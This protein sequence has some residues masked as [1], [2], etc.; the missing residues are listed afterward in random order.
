MEDCVGIVREEDELKQGV[1]RLE[2]LKPRVAQVK[3]PGA[4]QY[5]P[6]W[7]EAIA[8]KSL[9]VSSEA[10]ARAALLRKESRGAHT[11]VDY[12]GE[13]DEWLKYNIVI[14]KG[15]ADGEMQ[16]EKI[17]RPAPTPYLAEIANAK[18]EDL[19]AGKV[20]ANAPED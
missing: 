4:S 5:N 3:A 20:G 13:R 9:L 11:R 8:L 17:E 14:R 10:V 19:E 1:E 12:E 6:G 15:G 7:H 2:A 18:I 16:V